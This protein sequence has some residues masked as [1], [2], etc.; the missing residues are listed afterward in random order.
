M[1]AYFVLFKEFTYISISFS[2][3]TD[4]FLKG[5]IVQSLWF[6]V[7]ETMKKKENK[8]FAYLVYFP[9]FISLENIKKTVKTYN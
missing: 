8:N 5:G 4:T 2:V 9:P 6:Y 7:L 1:A 3:S